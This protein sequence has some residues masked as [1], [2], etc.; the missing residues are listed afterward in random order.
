MKRPQSKRPRGFTLIELLVVIA[1][2]GVLIALLLPAVQAAREAARRAQCVNN[3]KQLGLAMHNYESSNQVFPP[4]MHGGAGAVYGNFT[5]YSG[6]LPYVEQD[7]LY[8]AFNFNLS[9]YAGGFGHYY[10]W[11]FAAQ[12]TGHGTQVNTFLCPSN[13]ATGQVGMSYS[14]QW[15]IPKAAVTDYVF[16]GGADNFV[17][18]PFL[19]ERRRGLSGIDT[20][21]RIAEVRDGL[22][23]TIMMG[24]AAGG[25]EANRFVAVGFGPNRVCTPLA[26]Y[27]DAKNYDNLLFQAYGRRRNW[28]ATEFIVGG[29]VSSTV[30]ARGNPYRMND[31]GY[32]SATD[33]IGTAAADLGQTVP[34]FRSLHPGG[35]NFLFGDGSVRFLKNTISPPVYQGVATIKG[36]EVLSSDAY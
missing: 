11:S 16:S 22:N 14:T 5:G 34:N 2:I 35:C 6:L 30:D 7:A 36:G 15:T 29:I 13:R 9:L 21:T 28:G 25:N 32:A 23:Q 3:L 12:S 20:W 4:A 18:P 31:C 17:S 10:G 33:H 8:N 26:Q 19:D 24:E 27:A 1:I